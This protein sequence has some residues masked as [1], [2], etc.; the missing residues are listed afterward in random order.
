MSAKSVHLAIT[1]GTGFVGRAVI[2]HALDAGHTVSALI[3]T[4]SRAP[5]QH[6]NLTWIT[7]ALG[8]CD[9]DLVADADCVVHIAGLIKAKRRADYFAINATAAGNLARA[10]AEAGVGRFVLLSSMAARKPG[11]SDYAASKRAGEEAVS[12]EFSK[13]VAVIRAPAVFGPGDVA[14][15]PFYTAMQRGL[16]PVP[17][18]RGWNRR[19]LSM[20]YV[21]DLARDIISEA[22]NGAYDG[23]FVS[24]ATITETTWPEFAK[25]CS[26]VANKQIK[27]VPLPLALLY[28][29]AAMTSLTSRMFGMGHLTLGKLSEFLYQDW[30]SEDTVRN[31]T[32]SPAALEQTLSYY[33]VME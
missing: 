11:L 6:S 26:Q 28:P 14:T 8:T 3:R 31:A 15:A 30:S 17:G 7:G 23:Q 21:E 32:P 2:Q 33:K 5:I 22:V 18:G 24:P 13:N 25:T 20:V 10:A 12:H 1:G 27:A 29:V 4:P 19:K 16:L 9:A